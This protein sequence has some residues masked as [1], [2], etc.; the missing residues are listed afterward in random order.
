MSHRC[1]T[2][3]HLSADNSSTGSQVH[4][5]KDPHQM[6]GPHMALV[7]YTTGNV[8]TEEGVINDQRRAHC[9]PGINEATYIHSGD[10]ITRF[11]LLSHT[12]IED[13]V[14]VTKSKWDAKMT[15]RRGISGLAGGEW[16]PRFSL[17]GS[18]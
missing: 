1:S 18:A 11:C 6:K 8:Q 16:E 17:G 9:Y 7:I 5:P 14:V 13:K 3:P 15:W 12:T 4:S 10:S 2:S